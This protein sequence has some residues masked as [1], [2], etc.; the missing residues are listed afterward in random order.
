[1]EGRLL[2]GEREGKGKKEGREGGREGEGPS[3]LPIPLSPR[4][5]ILSQKKK[6][7]NSSPSFSSFLNKSFVTLYG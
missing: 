4:Q 7:S 3:S 2:Q 1:M 6:K 5:N